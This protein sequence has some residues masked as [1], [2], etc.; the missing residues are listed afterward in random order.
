MNFLVEKGKQKTES[1]VE[2]EILRYNQLCKKKTTCR[3]LEDV[4]NCNPRSQGMI[5]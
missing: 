3:A 1:K 4:S 5:V 2:S